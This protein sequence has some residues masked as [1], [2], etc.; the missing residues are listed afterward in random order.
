MTAFAQHVFPIERLENRD[1][2]EVIY[3]PF[4]RT[5]VDTE[6]SLEKAELI[7][8][9]YDEDGRL[10]ALFILAPEHPR[11]LCW[12]LTQNYAARRRGDADIFPDLPVDV[13]EDITDRIQ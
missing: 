12:K 13:Y 5:F 6:V 2:G 11:I 4:G 3:L 1:T 7:Y 8:R 10:T 9:E